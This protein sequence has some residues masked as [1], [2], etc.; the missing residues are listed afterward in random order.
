MPDFSTSLKDL[1]PEMKTVATDAAIGATTASVT[2][3]E[4]STPNLSP[5][6]IIY[7]VLRLIPLIGGGFLLRWGIDTNNWTG[8]QLMMF[9]GIISIVGGMAW[10]F[11]Q[12][13]VQARREHQIA[14][15]SAAA[16]AAATQSANRQVEVA[17]QPPAATV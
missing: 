13:Q 14:L 8:E 12:K 2:S 9:A 4:Q 7:W 16:S 11:I 3:V 15:A 10:S 6:T 17:V 5:V 1:T